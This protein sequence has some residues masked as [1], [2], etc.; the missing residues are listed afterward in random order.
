MRT[1]IYARYS[2]DQQREASIEDQIEICRRY[3]ERQGWTVVE[4][5]TDRALSGA[6]RFRSAFQQMQADGEGG[7]FD[8]FVDPGCDGGPTDGAVFMRE[9]DPFAPVCPPGTACYAGVVPPEG[10]CG[11]EVFI[12]ICAPE[13]PGEQGDPCL[14]HTDCSAGHVCVVTG[15]GTQC[16]LFCDLA[17]G[18]PRCPRGLICRSTD[19]PGYGGCF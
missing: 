16:V 10:P 5:Y 11:E 17:G 1:V 19:V 14:G 9:C 6:S 7:R 13:G 3:A 8:V 12:T 4:V 18:E 2:S 15:A